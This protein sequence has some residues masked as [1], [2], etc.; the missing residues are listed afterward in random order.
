MTAFSSPAFF[1]EMSILTTR[2]TVAAA[3]IAFIAGC[4]TTQPIPVVYEYHVERVA[5]LPPPR[6]GLQEFLDKM[7]PNGWVLDQLIVDGDWRVVMKR[8][9]RP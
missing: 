7:A 6:G 4:S 1:P 2:I 5:M 8:P 3:M 9:V